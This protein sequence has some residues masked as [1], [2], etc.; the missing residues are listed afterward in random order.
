MKYRKIRRKEERNQMM[1][2]DRE[3][4]MMVKDIAKKYGVC[5]SR[6]SKILQNQKRWNEE[7]R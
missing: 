3:S 1:L 5:C 6:A 4:G 2:E 7:E